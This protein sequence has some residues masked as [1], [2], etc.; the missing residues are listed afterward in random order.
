MAEIPTNEPTVLSET[1]RWLILMKPPGWLSVRPASRD[2]R[3]VLGDWL[4]G[5]S[6]AELFP[7]HR[8]DAE[9]SGVILFAKGAEAHREA[10]LWFQ[11][12]KVR[13]TYHALAS[14]QP[15]APMSR[16]SEPVGGQAALSQIEVKERFAGAFLAQVTPRTG[17]RHQIR[18]HLASKGNPILGDTE[19]GGPRALGGIEIARVA[20][21]AFRL[22]LPGGER[23]EAQWAP[24]FAAWVEALRSG[25]P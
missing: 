3:P 20:L 10:S 24:D 16:V 21:H 9:T 7:V 4:K 15:S 5:R 23:F 25:R 14:G 2:P 22:E 11:S 12:R 17:R 1:S 6:G 13:K 18:I 19:Y 8:L